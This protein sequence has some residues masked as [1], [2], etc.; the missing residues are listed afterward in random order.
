[1]ALPWVRLGTSTGQRQR[2]LR[3]FWPSNRSG[4]NDDVFGTTEILAFA[5]AQARMTTDLELRR[6]RPSTSLGPE[7]RRIWNYGDSGVR[8]R[9]GQKDSVR[10]ETYR[11]KGITIRN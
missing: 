2:Q 7:G 6:F 1:M 4:Q 5:F 3:R 8:L 10:V 9:S 11:S